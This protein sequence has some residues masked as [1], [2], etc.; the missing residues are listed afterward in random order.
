MAWG[1]TRMTEKTMG[2]DLGDPVGSGVLRAHSLSA[3]YWQVAALHVCPPDPLPPSSSPLCAWELGLHSP[4]AR[5]TLGSTRRRGE[6]S[7]GISF[8]GSLAPGLAAPSC[9]RPQF[10]PPLHSALSLSLD[11]GHISPS[12]CLLDL[13][14]SWLSTITSPRVL[15]HCWH[16]SQSLSI[17]L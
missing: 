3:I 12:L 14:W 9:Q 17:P 11:S 10:S 13:G 1:Q 16:L 5:A 6:G 8:L 7:R 15:H 4:H 2:L